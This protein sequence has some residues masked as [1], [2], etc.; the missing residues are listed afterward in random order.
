RRN[1]ERRRAAEPFRDR[2]DRRDRARG[3]TRRIRAV[4]LGGAG[5][6]VRRSP[7]DDLYSVFTPAR[8]G[9]HNSGR[10]NCWSWLYS[11]AVASRPPRS[12]VRYAPSRGP[13][14]QR[15]DRRTGARR[16]RGDV[17]DLGG[18]A[19]TTLA[20]SDAGAAARLA[21]WTAAAIECGTA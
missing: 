13:R 12:L 15:G 14:P 1:S 5:E 18:G 16:L 3:P 19:G 11:A 20:E 17:G 10:Y 7:D 4:G 9:G 21:R 2:R 6:G 8:R